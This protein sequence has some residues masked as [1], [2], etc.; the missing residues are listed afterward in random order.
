V[1]AYRTETTAVAVALMPSHQARKSQSEL[2]G[3]PVSVVTRRTKS[4]EPAIGS[5]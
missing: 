1:Q 4:S 2:V 3:T 5:A